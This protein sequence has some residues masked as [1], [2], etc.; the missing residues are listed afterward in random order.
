ME[1]VASGV[2]RC[3]LNLAALAPA[4]TLT[5]LANFDGT[6]GGSPDA[7][8]V[9]GLDGNFYGTTCIHGP[10]SYG[11]V[12]KITPSGTLTTLYGFD[13]PDGSCPYGGLVLATNGNFYGATSAGGTVSNCVA[14]CGTIFE[15]TPDGTLTTLYDLGG[16]IGYYPYGGLIQ[17]GGDFYGATYG[18]T[19]GGYGAIFKIT[20][21]GTLTT[22]A[23]FNY[24]DGAYPYDALIE[25]ADGSF[26]GT[27][28]LGGA[29]DFGAVFQ[30]TPDGN[31]VA[32][33][34]FDGAN[35]EL[36]YASVISGSNG[37]FYGVASQGGPQCAGNPGVCGSGTA[38]A[39]SPGGKIDVLH[40]FNGTDGSRP[41]SLIQ[42]TDRNF[43]G[44]TLLGGGSQSGTIFEMTPTGTL[45]TLHD[46][47]GTDGAQ[48]VGALLEATD[49]N[50]YGTTQSGAE[51]QGTVFQLSTGLAPFVMIVPTAA[52]IGATVMILGSNLTGATNVSFNGGSAAFTVVSATEITATVPTGAESGNVRVNTPGSELTS[53]VAFR[54]RP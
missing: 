15:I 20:P 1:L 22:L 7:P 40:T 49:G 35:G 29:N 21:G 9:Q 34:S 8:L 32:L 27:T 5:T 48:P 39:V 10:N 33:A 18:G 43:Y 3:L 25:G 36:P 4:Q 54:V 12:F 50:F 51:G 2:C 13:G 24:T 52:K 23:S 53:N 45:T 14:A 42:A 47:D 26:Y 31:L 37:A 28:E 46:F 17:A 44:T 19:A 41:R 30:V 6:N 11:T 38:F 16:T